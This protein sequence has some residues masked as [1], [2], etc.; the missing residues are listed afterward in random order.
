[1]RMILWLYLGCCFMVCKVALMLLRSWLNL[2]TLFKE[3]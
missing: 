2:K 1:M 3:G